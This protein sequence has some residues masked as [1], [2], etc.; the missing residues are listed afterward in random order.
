MISRQ[1]KLYRR[2][3]IYLISHDNE[4]VRIYEHYTLITKKHILFYRDSINKLDF[5]RKNG[6]EKWTSYTF[7][8]NVY[9]KFYS[10]HHERICSAVDQ[11]FKSEDFAVE[12]F[13]QQSDLE[14]F[15][16]NSSQL[17]ISYLQQTEAELP[18][19]QTSE[20]V[21]KKSKGKGGKDK[22]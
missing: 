2:I 5:T 13:S 12:F 6:K 8:R 20:P 19:S 18:S 17:T 16:Q 9:D 3:F 22:T 4:V 21:F 14:Y 1:N 11:L 7:T 10:I 15:E